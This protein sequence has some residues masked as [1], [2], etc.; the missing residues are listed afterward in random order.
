M[1]RNYRNPLTS[2][3]YM[4]HRFALSLTLG[5]SIL[6]FSAHSVAEASIVFTNFGAG[7]SYDITSGNPVGNAFDGNDYAEA[8]SFQPSAS[9]PLQLLRLALSCAFSCQDPLTVSL[10]ANSGGQ[11]GSVLESFQL[12]GSA[13]GPIGTNN[14]L[15]VLTSVLHPSLTAGTEYW[16]SVGAGLTDSAA[17]NLNITGDVFDQA[18]SSDNGATWFSPSGL[19][20]GALEV[21]TAT[22]N[23]GSPEPGSSGLVVGGALLLGL[24]LRQRRSQQPMRRG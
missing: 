15:L 24:L 18:I 9:G 11:P 22:Q 1:N 14:P 12:D 3:T 7:L 10:T 21:D 2:A 13:L 23:G 19:T 8:N 16:V 17:W 5:A 20:P 4:T 6:V